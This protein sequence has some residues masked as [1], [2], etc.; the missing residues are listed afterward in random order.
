MTGTS[1]MRPSDGP[2]KLSAPSTITV[3]GLDPGFG[4]T[5]YAIA[6]VDPAA[7]A[8]SRVVEVGLVEHRPETT[9]QV[10]RPSDDLRRAREQWDVISQLI[11]RENVAVLAIEMTSRSQYPACAFGFGVMT[12]MVAALKLPVV[13]VYPRQVKA[14]T[15]DSM[16]TKGDIIAWALNTFG[17]RVKGWPTSSRPN[18]LSM[19]LHGKHVAPSAEHPADALATIAAA[20]RSDQFQ[21]ALDTGSCSS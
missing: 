7:P 21:F 6:E 4:N 17:R 10:S 20:L 11:T 3:L 12:G 5:G 19:K 13:E 2:T 18:S 15:G 16:A 14:V 1:R 8:I 9:G